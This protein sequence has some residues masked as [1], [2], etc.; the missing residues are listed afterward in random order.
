[1]ASVSRADV[2]D[3]QYFF[4]Q[5]AAAG[6]VTTGTDIQTL[7]MYSWAITVVSVGGAKGTLSFQYT[8]YSGADD[9]VLPFDWRTTYVEGSNG[10]VTGTGVFRFSKSYDPINNASRY[11]RIVFTPSAGST[12]NIYL[13]LTQKAQAAI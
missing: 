11:L 12:G 10:S 8:D 5:S 4:G 9:V 7:G 6:N 1:M 3:L 2:V 13:A